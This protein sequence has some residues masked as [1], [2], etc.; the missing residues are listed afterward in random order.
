MNTTLSKQPNLNVGD[1]SLPR[2]RPRAG[3]LCVGGYY[4]DATHVP[5]P[6]PANDASR[7]RSTAHVEANP[8]YER[9]RQRLRQ[10]KG[11]QHAAGKTDS[12]Q[13]EALADFEAELLRLRY[14]FDVAF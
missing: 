6:V 3:T 9:A 12:N 7:P 14:G 5:R 10:S 8:W 11:G 13:R 1:C 4:V 2:T